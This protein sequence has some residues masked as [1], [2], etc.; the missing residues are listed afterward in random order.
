MLTWV[1]KWQLTFQHSDVISKYVVILEGILWRALFKLSMG[2]TV[3]HTEH[4]LVNVFAA[5]C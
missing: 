5:E 1:I 3:V 4:V 2:S